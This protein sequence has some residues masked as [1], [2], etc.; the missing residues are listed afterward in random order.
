MPRNTT[1]IHPNQLKECKEQLASL[2][3]KLQKQHK[4]FTSEMTAEKIHFEEQVGK[5][6][7]QNWEFKKT[8]YV[9]QKDCGIY[10]VERDCQRKRGNN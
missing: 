5:L 3:D 4:H 7:G 9:Q 1:A 6:K 10:W 2:Q 8:C